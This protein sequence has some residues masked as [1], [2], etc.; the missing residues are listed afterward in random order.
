MPLLRRLGVLEQL[1]PDEVLLVQELAR[2]PVRDVPAR[3]VLH[4]AGQAAAP[5]LLLSGWGCRAR[6]LLDG[7]R[8]IVSFLLP[9]DVTG[10][11]P[12][13]PSPCAVLALSPLRL[14]DAA[15]LL[16]AAAEQPLRFPALSRAL[17]AAAQAEDVLLRNQIVRL[18]QQTAYERLAGMLAEFLQRLRAAGLADGDSFAMPLTQ[19]AL[20]DALGLSA[21]HVNRTLQQM[22]RNGL[23]EL[24][25][26]LVVIRDPE[27]LRR[28]AG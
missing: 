20:G 23:L 14:L 3:A 2:Q 26:R 22:R 24:R 25:G 15:P 28:L 6:F 1:S 27:A 16:L 21:V 5:A 17:R 9:G 12:P 18:G 4:P 10:Q 8:Q 11:V 19:D 13:L 7:R